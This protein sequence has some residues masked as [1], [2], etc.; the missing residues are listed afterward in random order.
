MRG[1]L[2]T[3]YPM[4]KESQWSGAITKQQADDLF[5]ESKAIIRSTA[6]DDNQQVMTIGEQA[7]DDD[8]LDEAQM[9]ELYH[10]F[11][12]ESDPNS[13]VL[14]R[15][16][17]EQCVNFLPTAPDGNWMYCAERIRLTNG[18]DV[19]HL[20]CHSSG[21]RC[22]TL[23]R[24]LSYDANSDT[25]LVQCIPVTGRTHQLRIHLQWLGYPIAN[26]ACYSGNLLSSN[27][28]SFSHINQ[29]RDSLETERDRSPTCDICLGEYQLFDLDGDDV[30][31]LDQRA[32]QG[33]DPQHAAWIN[34]HHVCTHV[35]L[36]ALA[37]ACPEGADLNFVTEPPAWA[38]PDFDARSEC[39]Q[40]V[41]PQPY[42]RT[43][44]LRRVAKLA[45]AQ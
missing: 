5:D 18:N 38:R 32:E 6:A 44:I 22:C 24:R 19:R 29:A 36:H 13:G 45:S 14:D 27:S 40:L 12:G 1:Q 2:D 11:L 21:R 37:Y 7:N 23:V 16:F 31:S 28:Y 35:W 43:A 8:A 41:S 30:D 39:S 3:T 10:R 17:F 26:D 15:N 4:V 25:S 42:H 33:Q 9:I 20:T 34:N